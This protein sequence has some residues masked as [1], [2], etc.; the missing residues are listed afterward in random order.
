M[1]LAWRTGGSVFVRSHALIGDW[2]ILIV[3]VK[4]HFNLDYMPDSRL[5]MLAALSRPV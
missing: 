2:D 4:P 1:N 5:L 3:N